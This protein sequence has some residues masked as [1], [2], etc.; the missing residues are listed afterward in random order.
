M[1][2]ILK[3][4]CKKTKQQQQQNIYVPITATFLDIVEKNV[5]KY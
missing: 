4:I 5:G 2:Q 1:K 3:H